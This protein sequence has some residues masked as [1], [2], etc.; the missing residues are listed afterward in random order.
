MPCLEITVPQLSAEVKARL[1][2]ELTDLFAELTGF[3]REIFAIHFNEYAPGT[4]ALGGEIH[5]GKTGRPY[6][7]FVLYSPRLKRTVKQQLV[8]KMSA[9]FAGIV[10]R[11]EWMPVIHLCEHPYDNVGVEGKLLSDSYEACANSRFY[12]ELPPD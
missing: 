11:S 1:S 7:H 4:V 9:V 6:L 3:E 10:G 8:E 5:D 2:K 12:Y